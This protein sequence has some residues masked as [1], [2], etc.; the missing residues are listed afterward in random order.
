M[1]KFV[2]LSMCTGTLTGTYLKKFLLVAYTMPVSR[3]Y[4]IEIH[5]L[6]YTIHTVIFCSDCIVPFQSQ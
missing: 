3:D 1:Y 4:E 5:V 2:D 6:K